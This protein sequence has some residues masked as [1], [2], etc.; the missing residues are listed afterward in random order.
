M[1]NTNL[2]PKLLYEVQTLIGNLQDSNGGSRPPTSFRNICFDNFQDTKR[3]INKLE[4]EVFYLWEFVV[5]NGEQDEAKEY[6]E[7]NLDSE[8]PFEWGS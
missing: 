7:E 4:R 3:Y 8:I 5:Q 2:L 1:E 6:V